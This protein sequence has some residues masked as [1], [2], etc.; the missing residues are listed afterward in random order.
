VFPPIV[1]I[2][3]TLE[4]H[5]FLSYQH[6]DSLSQLLFKE[7]SIKTHPGEY[8]LYITE[9]FHQNGKVRLCKVYDWRCNYENTK[10]IE[11]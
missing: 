5:Y 3:P 7:P 6:V 9:H 11:E 4:F 10:A 1:G 8:L 2:T